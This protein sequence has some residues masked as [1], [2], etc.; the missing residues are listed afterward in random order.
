MKEVHEQEDPD[1]AELCPPH[2][3]QTRLH[4][5]SSVN[6]G[7]DLHYIWTNVGVTGMLWGRHQ[8]LSTQSYSQC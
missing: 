4:H 7:A 8:L 1:A 5:F 6:L 2:T 3:L